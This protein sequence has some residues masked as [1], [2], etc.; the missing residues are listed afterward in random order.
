MTH[1]T[2]S[3]TVNGNVS[4]KSDVVYGTAQG[5]V[6]GLLIY[7]IYDVL[8]VANGNTKVVMY[9]DV[10]NFAKFCKIENGI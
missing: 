9:A 8:R 2:Q 5:S 1:R 6:L 4:G 10:N 3:T 7:I